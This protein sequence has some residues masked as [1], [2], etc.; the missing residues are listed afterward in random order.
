[1]RILMVFRIP[2]SSF[3]RRCHKIKNWHSGLSNINTGNS[4][5]FNDTYKKEEN[6]TLNV[7]PKRDDIKVGFLWGK[8]TFLIKSSTW[9]RNPS[10]L[11]TPLVNL[12]EL[13]GSPVQSRCVILGYIVFYKSCVPVNWERIKSGFTLSE[14]WNEI[15]QFPIKWMV[16]GWNS[17]AR[18][19]KQNLC[20]SHKV[21]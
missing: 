17:T 10:C 16:M 3:S 8:D 2:F 14:S 20:H 18:L 19:G 13:S 21:M 9:P 5:Y 6:Y 15:T 4:L 12:V 11:M 7:M 1:M